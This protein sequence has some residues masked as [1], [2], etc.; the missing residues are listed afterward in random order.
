MTSKEKE[1]IPCPKSGRPIT[2]DSINE[3]VTHY[4]HSRMYYNRTIIYVCC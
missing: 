4:T 3:C 1:L 2:I